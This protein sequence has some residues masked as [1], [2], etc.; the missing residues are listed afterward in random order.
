MKKVMIFLL[1]WASLY[2][3][4]KENSITPS[5]SLKILGTK[6]IKSA[7]SIVPNLFK[8]SYHAIKLMRQ[9]N[10][11]YLDG[12]A[13]GNAANKPGSIA[14][15]GVGL[16]SLCIADAMY[17]KTNDAANW[18]AKSAALVNSTLQTFINFK[19]NGAI[20]KKGLFHRYFNVKT[21]FKDGGW[22]AEYSTVD[23]AIFA[24][25]LTFCKNYFSNNIPI[26]TKANQLLS[27]MD[28]TAAISS[29]SQQLFMVL[30]KNGVGSNPTSAYNEY[31]IVA[32]LAKNADSLHPGYTK[33]QAYWNSRYQNPK[34]G[35]IH[36]SNYWGI[37]L[38]SDGSF[39]PNFIPQFTYYYCSYF[40]TNSDYMTYFD[41][42]RKSDALFWKKLVPEISSYKWGLGAGENPGNGY[43]ANAIDRNDL[44]IL[45]PHII[46]GFIPVYPQAVNDLKSLYGNGNGSS[47]YSL[48]G[49]S[50]RK[51]LWRYSLKNTSLRCS[52]IQAVDFST[53]LYGLASL[54][55]NLG[56]NFFATYNN[57]NSTAL[58]Q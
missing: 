20:N 10:G 7:N 19:N 34:T 43:S 13:L 46:A 29:D 42:S 25:G 39:I 21:G 23:N 32:W 31:M 24:M 6:S 15:N 48:P 12:L 38:I 40:K 49:S 45:S 30:D 56:E 28:Y 37:D 50:S 16:I 14:A 4:D 53:M 54:S 27:A 1:L 22:S 52:Y 3:C 5:S 26:V 33:S 41:N 36:H 9:S 51:V 55:E 35:S 2:S 57:L 8:D 11:I 18:E 44:Q 47:V 58:G 17:T